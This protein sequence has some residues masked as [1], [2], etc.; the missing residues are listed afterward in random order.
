MYLLAINLYFT[1]YNYTLMICLT[2]NKRELYYNYL[3]K[4]TGIKHEIYLRITLTFHVIF[5]YPL[6]VTMTI[7]FQV[8]SHDLVQPVKP[9]ILPLKA[10]SPASHVHIL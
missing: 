7:P 8:V 5:G 2:P 6:L 9:S 10:H 3:Y 1:M 4:K